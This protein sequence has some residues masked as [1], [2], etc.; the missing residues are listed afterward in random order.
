M[1]E[2]EQPIPITLPAR[3]WRGCTVDRISST[4]RLFFSSTTPLTTHC[5]YTAKDMSRSREPAIAT[6]VSAS[7][8]SASGGWSVAVVSSGAGG[9]W[10]RSARTAVS[11]T[12]ASFR[13]D[14][15]AEDDPVVAEEQER[16]DVLRRERLTP[17]G[18]RG[19]H[20]QPHFA[21][22]NGSAARSRAAPSPGGAGAV[23]ATPY[24]ASFESAPFRAVDPP[25]SRSRT[26]VEARNARLRSR[27]R[28]SRPATSAIARRPLIA[29]PAPGRAPRARA[30]R[31]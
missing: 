25:T 11:V 9:S 24:V 8:A 22:S 1:R 18:R 31:S 14:V 7:V 2:S 29:P 20:L 5:P 10:R 28:I 17:G 30:A 19:D 3:R 13:V 6:R 4:T 26:S 27:S 12:A 23:T 15:R 21:S 16:V